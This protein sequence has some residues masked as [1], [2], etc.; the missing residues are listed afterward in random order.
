MYKNHKNFSTK[1]FN[2]Y[3]QQVKLSNKRRRNIVAE[4]A[5][6]TGYEQ[7]NIKH[8]LRGESKPISLDVVNHIADYFGI[9]TDD[10]LEE[11]NDEKIIKEKNVMYE[12][13][14]SNKLFRKMYKKIIKVIE[15]YRDTDGFTGEFL[16]VIYY[17]APEQDERCNP[18]DEYD[19]S[20]AYNERARQNNE[21]I[22]AKYASQ[23]KDTIKAIRKARLILTEQIID[24]LILLV[25]DIFDEANCNNESNEVNLADEMV[26]ASNTK[27]YYS[28]LESI[29]KDY[30]P[31]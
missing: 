14:R 17:P 12:E 15:M 19:E 10:L 7:S 5:T 23:L 13:I 1:A 27:R 30:L 31:S 3:Y 21:K 22:N 6:A 2:D 16:N 11:F 4:L 20:K 29:L 25:F 28:T 26:V 8:W 24:K 9:N 18:Y